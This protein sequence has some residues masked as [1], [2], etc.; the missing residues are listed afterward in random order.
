M[1]TKIRLFSI[2]A[3]LTAAALWAQ[4]P[5][6]PGAPDNSANTGNAV[7]PPSRVAR[8]DLIQG[9]VSFQPAGVQDWTAA[10]MNY[11][12]TTGDHLYADDNS[13][14]ELE[15]GSS[16]I[17][18]GPR[19]GMGVV[20]LDDHTV[21]LRLDQGAMI[22]RLKSLAEGESYEI[23]TTQGAITLLRPGEYRIDTDPDRNATMV[24]VRSGDAEV[25]ANGGAFPVHPRS[26]AYF[27][28]D[29]QPQVQSENPADDFDRFSMDRD[30]QE[31]R[32]PPPR[33]V[34][35]DMP[36]WQDLDRN[37]TWTETP[38]YG[39]VWRPQV[40][41]GWAPYRYGHWAWI[42][43]WGWT[44]ID[45]APWGFAPFHYGR[46]V[47][48]GG[49]WAWVPGPVAPRPV[50]AP[51]LVAFVGGPGFHVGVG[52]GSVAWFPLGPR[53]PFVPAY[54]VS[55]VYVN[56]VNVT[57]VNVTNVTVVNRTYV[58]QR[59]GVTAVN[60]TTFT[61]AQPVNRSLVVIPHEQ[62]VR[63]Q[64]VGTAPSVAPQRAS[65]VGMRVGNV[66]HP[67]P[68]VMNRQVYVRNS[69]PPPPVSFAARQ[70]ALQANPGR[71]VDPQTM[72][73]LRQESPVRQSSYRPAAPPANQG[74]PQRFGG[75]NQRGGNPSMSNQPAS[76]QP[77]PNQQNNPRNAGFGGY[78]NRNQ[79][80]P[81]N[82]PGAGQQPVGTS[83]P[84]NRANPQNASEP[85]APVS[86]RNRES[87]TPP[88]NTQEAQQ[89]RRQ[90][91]TQA[92]PQEH[93]QRP[94]HQQQTESRE[95]KK[96]DNKKDDQKQ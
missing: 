9:Q 16:P 35:R 7:D 42:E 63:A 85:P 19:G 40:V 41:A 46:W 67:P 6:Y 75:S 39:A 70:Q 93:Q 21:Q 69:P 89:P 53:E 11:P 31:D 91:Q 47:T 12:M 57:T 22:V 15:V 79:S 33:Y 3:T 29:G 17:R 94:Q 43:P 81:A 60:Q 1:T 56:R 26:T 78:P 45:D 10:T 18:V 24:T 51:A 37:G 65:I 49:G 62:I 72:H 59:V 95:N 8:L 83:S 90:Q 76:N 71:P 58:N 80:T 82:N 27:T 36:G 50:Y 34:S 64:V 4:G 38:E 73:Q 92:Q 68:A 32:M 48:V 23:D 86:R 52:I 20:N 87:N 61:S 5:G 44:W 13:Y 66:P 28:G 55:T 25:T 77:A 84:P 30:Q 54:H 2:A 88:N 74:S 14:A 96:K